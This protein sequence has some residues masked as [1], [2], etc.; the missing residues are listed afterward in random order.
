MLKDKLNETERYAKKC[1]VIYSIEELRETMDIP[2]T[3]QFV[4]LKDRILDKAKKD[5]KDSTDLKFE[6]EV[7]QKEVKKVTHIKF[8]V[9][10]NRKNNSKSDSEEVTIMPKHLDS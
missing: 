1:E 4:H 2:L 3:Y 6:W 9:S 8:I 5:L 10:K 7:A